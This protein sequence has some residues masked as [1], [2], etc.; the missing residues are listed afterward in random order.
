MLQQPDRLL[1]HQLRD[2]IAQHRP[3]GVEALVGLADVRQAHVVQQDFLHDEDGDGFAELRPGLHDAE[4]ERDDFR[5][6][7]E[8]YY[9]RAVV[10]DQG[11]DHAEGGQAEVFEGAGFGGGV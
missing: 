9:F 8:V 3:D 5:G 7:E 6:E 1:L 11:A 4:A 10:F 2:H